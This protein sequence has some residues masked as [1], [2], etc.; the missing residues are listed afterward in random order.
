MVIRTVSAPGR[1]HLCV[2]PNGARSA[3][4][5]H[6]DGFFEAVFPGET[7]VFPYRLP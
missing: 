3:E 5:V 4:R 7:G 6:R 2:R 1:V